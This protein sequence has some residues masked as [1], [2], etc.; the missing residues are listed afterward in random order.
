MGG[1][2]PGRTGDTEL[3][4]WL[5]GAPRPRLT[6][7]GDE[8]LGGS[9]D[10]GDLPAAEVRAVT[11]QLAAA[12]ARPRLTGGDSVRPAHQGRPRPSGTIGGGHGCPRAH[13]GDAPPWTTTCKWGPPGLW[14][15]PLLC[16]RPRGPQRPPGGLRHH[17]R[18]TPT[19]P[20]STPPRAPPQV[21]AAA[22]GWL[23]APGGSPCTPPWHGAPPA[24]GGMTG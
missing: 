13:S 4:A 3:S 14:P 12:P 19:P 6:P 15:R 8:H 2:W 17:P 5:G 7:Q 10:R 23:R 24:R 1:P 22:S 11:A 18:P 21:G 9:T 16:D 20:A